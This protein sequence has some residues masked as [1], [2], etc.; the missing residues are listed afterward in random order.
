MDLTNFR[1]CYPDNRSTGY[2]LGGRIC[3]QS[4]W[5]TQSTWMVRVWIWAI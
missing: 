2:R 4:A 1:P 5:G 3:G